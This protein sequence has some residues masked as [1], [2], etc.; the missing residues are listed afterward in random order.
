MNCAYFIYRLNHEKLEHSRWSVWKITTK[1][2]PCITGSVIKSL[3][4]QIYAI[5]RSI[6]SFPVAERWTTMQELRILIN[7]DQPMDADLLERALRKSGFEFVS[8]RVD[9]RPSF[10]TALHEF[11]PDIIMSD[12]RLPT[13][14]GMEALELANDL[15]P[16][17]PFVIVTGAMNEEIAV[18]C[19]RAGAD[20]YVLKDHLVR[21]GPAVE[22]AVAKKKVELEKR[23]AN[24]NLASSEKKFRAIF[25]QSNDAIFLLDGLLFVDC[26]TTAVTLFG[27][28]RDRILSSTPLDFSPEVQPNGVTSRT[29]ADEKINMA[30]CGTLQNF[31]W[32]HQ[33]P[34]GSI[35]DVDIC[36]STLDIEGKSFILAI[37]RDITEKK[38]TEL[39]LNEQREKYKELSQEFNVLLD[40]LPDRIL[41]L[42]PA[43]E[44]VWANRAARECF[45]IAGCEQAERRCFKLVHGISAPIEGC[46]VRE[47]LQTGAPA[48]NV[49]KVHDE[50]IWEVRSVPLKNW[51]ND[52]GNVIEICRDIT[53]IKKLEQQLFHAQKMEA[54]GQ[55]AGGIAHD[56]NNILTAM[57]GYG[58]LLQMRMVEDEAAMHYVEQILR[59]SERAAALTQGLLAFS[60][61]KVTNLEPTD[62][63]DTILNVKMFLERLVGEDIDIRTMLAGE[64]LVASVDQ[65]QMEQVFM[66]L[67]TNA[68]DAMPDGG[69]L[70]IA[71]SRC[72]MDDDFIRFHGFGEVGRY[73]QVDVSDTGM[74]MDENTCAR[75]F[76]PFFTTKEEGKGT[77]LGLSIVYGIIKEHKGYVAVKSKKGFGTTFTLYLP[78]IEDGDFQKSMAYSQMPT[79]GSETI[80]VAEDDDYVRETVVKFLRDYGYTVIEA[81]DGED[82]VEQYL[83]AKDRVR[84]LL[85]DVLMP[86]KGGREVYEEARALCPNIKVLFDSGYP[87][88]VLQGKG[89]LQEG[90]NYILKPISPSE[91]LKKVREVLDQ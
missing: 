7:E 81:V 85:L 45:M 73:L 26:N 28:A 41:L 87:L 6:R 62:V 46:P 72:Y 17:V 19:M 54:I 50:M 68:R 53:E 76:E 79:G 48:K 90:V 82:A 4:S 2:R 8:H 66:N 9:S 18:A 14:N 83:A 40:A 16:D 10:L 36:L 24:Q 80:L 55:L 35:F 51:N 84:L 58:N 20:D 11:M 59:N 44:V 52:P 47:S 34:D 60:R 78:L 13:F 37:L 56:F 22:S 63:N 88:H 25:E 29:L 64:P 89:I 42:S 70:S 1:N 30:N 49:L 61:K 65:S 39:E 43:Q 67:A 5:Q 3:R 74:G 38:R 69:T 15:A 57:I 21:I 23:Q 32:R 77:G 91:L 75:I 12:Y 31:E 71:T 33:R 27:V 86:K